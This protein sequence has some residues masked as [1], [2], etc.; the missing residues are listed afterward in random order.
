MNSLFP[1]RY[2]RALCGGA[3]VTFLVSSSLLLLSSADADAGNPVPY[4]NQPLVPDAPAPG[5]SGFTLTV[6]GT[7]FVSGSVV[8]WNGSARTTTFVNGSAV[9]SSDRG[10]RHCHSGYGLG[11]SGESCAR[12]RYL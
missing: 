4:I 1:L 2:R 7:G 9:D 5:G 12:R 8:D 11:D 3:M 10:L 6:N